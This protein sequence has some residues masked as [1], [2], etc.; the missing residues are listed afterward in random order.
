MGS[1]PAEQLRSF[2]EKTASEQAE[3]TALADN[4]RAQRQRSLQLNEFCDRAIAEIRKPDLEGCEAALSLCGQA[5]AIDPSCASAASLV[6]VVRA[7][8]WTAGVPF[9]ADEAAEA[10]R[11]A[12]QIDDFADQI[13]DAHGDGSTRRPAGVTRARPLAHERPRCHSAADQDQAPVA[14]LGNF[15][16][17]RR[18]TPQGVSEKENQKAKV[19]NQKCG[20]LGV[21]CPVAPGQV[22]TF[23]CTLHPGMKGRLVVAGTGTAGRP[24]VH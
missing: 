3:S 21:P 1:V 23:Y 12:R 20:R 18:R 10:R 7:Y 19:K 22:Y 9:T 4:L 5:L 6:G 17:F 16:H 13:A 14:A 11:A 24:A 2:P 15:L 8:Q